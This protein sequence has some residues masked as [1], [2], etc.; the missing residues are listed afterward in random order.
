[1]NLE[2]G[3]ID[4]P[5]EL[6]VFDDIVVSL[7]ALDLEYTAVRAHLENLHRYD[8]PA[9]TL[10][11][12]GRVAGTGRRMALA[13][14][15]QGPVAT[16]IIVHQA[17]LTFRP[18]LVLFTGIAGALWDSLGLGDVVVGDRV[19]THQSGAERP[20]G[21]YP[22]PWSWAPPFHILQRAHALHRDG[23][24]TDLLPPGRR[25]D[26]HFKA[27]ASG[28]VLVDSATSVTAGRIRLLDDAAAVE[29]EGT[30]FAQAGHMLQVDALMIRGISDHASGKA[31]TDRAGW[32]EVAAANAAAFAVGLVRTLPPPT[33]RAR[34][35]RTIELA[36]LRAVRQYTTENAAVGLAGPLL[37]PDGPL[38]DPQVRALLEGALAGGVA[39]AALALGQRWRTAMARPP[40]ERDLD[41]EARVL[42]GYFRNHAR[43]A[44]PAN[45]EETDDLDRDLADVR[46]ELA[47][48]AELVV[49]LGPG[50]HGTPAVR[51]H[52]YDQTKLI[53]AKTR[54]F[55]GRRFVFEEVTKTLAE[56]DCG[57]CLVTA[58]PGVGK[59]A[60]LSQ[61]VKDH[62]YVHHFNLLTANVTAPG[63]F[64]RNVCAQLV[65]TYGLPY[66][67]LPD[68]A[69]HDAGFLVELLGKAK[70]TVAAGEQIIV[71]VDA[72]DES[73]TT[74]LL[75]GVNPLFLPPD[76]PSG[77]YFVVTTR[78]GPDGPTPRLRTD[79]PQIHVEIKPLEGPNMAD[80]ST[81]VRQ[82]M[83]WP[84][85]RE[86]R[87]RQGLEES[88][89]IEYMAKKCEGNFMYLRHV[90][91]EIDRGGL[92]DRAMTELPAGLK[93]YYLDNFDRMRGSDEE[94]WFAYRLP[95]LATLRMFRRPVT[96]DQIA[97]LCGLPRPRVEDVLRRWSPFLVAES[98][99]VNNVRR[100]AYRIYHA[101]YADFL[102]EHTAAMEKELEDRIDREREDD[103][104]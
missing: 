25:P 32:R 73:D 23:P 100:R 14:A 29:M 92:A 82:R 5:V 67:D 53:E 98:V 17:V 63:T 69:G 88:R 93:S 87:K 101:S 33:D 22:R 30:G 77:C 42:L 68:R 50:G 99:V 52:H 95:V 34:A 45:S 12:V 37:R 19:Y 11:E 89:F 43:K 16:A 64:L 8:H 7:S 66:D 27:I 49:P 57:Y 40:A 81:Y 47:G 4:D 91:P 59:T 39:A 75:P 28:E 13:V 86:Y 18:R 20:D 72:L 46:T 65:A 35:G 90:L 97:A 48:L 80:V 76:L 3:V 62:G 51:M 31:A 2:M 60:L 44:G 54:G 36:L 83:D 84:G 26:V 21:F 58:L 85:V 103:D 10:F 96:V 94:T 38:A 56:E 102:A 55:V 9:G 24:W 41:E 71:A 78:L 61:L 104:G 70:A 1:M 74:Q 79:C 15:G 6:G